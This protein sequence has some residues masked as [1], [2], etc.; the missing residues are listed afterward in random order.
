M[1]SETHAPNANGSLQP[2]TTDHLCV[3]IYRECTDSSSPTGNATRTQW[4][5]TDGA[6]HS[7]AVNASQTDIVPEV[8]NGERVEW[9]NLADVPFSI[10]FQKTKCPFEDCQREYTVPPG[11]S[12]L[13]GIIRASINTSYSYTVASKAQ[14]NTARSSTGGVQR[15]NPEVIVRGI[16]RPDGQVAPMGR[17]L[18]GNPE[19]IVKG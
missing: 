8:R 1:D 10:V 12:V 3:V 19:V 7:L 16:F 15:G 5:G 17:R 13:S 11:R 14:D 4:V 18:R 9:I 2:Q 6:T